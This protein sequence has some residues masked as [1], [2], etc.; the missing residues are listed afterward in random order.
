MDHTKC[1]PM[2]DR[3]Y[4]AR[5]KVPKWSF[6]PF[7][8]TDEVVIYTVAKPAHYCREC[9]GFKLNAL[10]VIHK[11]VFFLSVS[12]M[13]VKNIFVMPPIWRHPYSQGMFVRI[14]WPLGAGLLVP[15][16]RMRGERPH[17]R[18]RRAPL[19]PAWIAGHAA[20]RARPPLHVGQ[21]GW[22]HQEC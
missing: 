21:A 17:S 6:K 9:C 8:C 3:T 7:D 16:V 14:R 10:C 5:K 12:C 19:A 2:G 22:R 18:V 4:N 11:F 1:C 15:V 20:S 13:F